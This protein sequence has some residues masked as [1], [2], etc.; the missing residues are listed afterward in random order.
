MTIDLFRDWDAA[1][2]LGALSMDERREYE[3]HFASCPTCAAAV[4]E[5]AGIPGILTKLDTDSAVALM[6][7][8]ID[9]PSTGH[10]PDLVQKLSRLVT[11]Q[12]H[13]ARRRLNV[14]MA[15]AAA[16]L[17]VFGILTGSSMQSRTHLG[18]P[19]AGIAT[20]TPVT[21][22]QIQ[23]NVMTADLRVT[24]KPWGTRFDWSCKYLGILT[25]RYSPKFYELVITDASGRKFTIATWSSTGPSAAELVTTSSLPIAEIRTV[26]IRATGSTLPL[27]RG[28]I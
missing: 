28:E 27:V 23:P 8:P 5:L 7:T 11:Q 24:S 20:G 25:G 6:S 19:S 9:L 3:R 21:M 2:V 22:S 12:Q 26:E 18:H 17:I 13:R 10:Q 15:A 4:A 14:G 1:Y 16:V